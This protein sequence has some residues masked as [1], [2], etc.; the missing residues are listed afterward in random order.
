ML[1]T[2]IQ[3]VLKCDSKAQAMDLC[4]AF[5]AFLSKIS[6]R[7][8]MFEVLQFGWSNYRTQSSL[9]NNKKQKS[10]ATLYCRTINVFY[11][12]N[13]SALPLTLSLIECTLF[14]LIFR[15]VLTFSFGAIAVKRAARQRFRFGAIFGID[16]YVLWHFFVT[17]ELCT[18]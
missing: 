16:K 15:M 18:T 9:C 11:S 8:L 7:P 2:F 1:T 13:K 3:H 4:G 10:L 17:D 5:F 14:S 6:Y 12:H